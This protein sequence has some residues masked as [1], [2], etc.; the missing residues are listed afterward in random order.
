M[1]Y[2]GMDVHARMTMICVLDSHGKRRM[3]K[4]VQGVPGAVVV[5]IEDLK[6]QLAGPLAICFE[7]SCGYGWLYERLRPLAEKVV[8]AHPG[9][10]RMIFRS[11]RKSD[12]IDA[13][14]LAKLLYL[15]E[16][17][18]VHVPQANKR[19]WRRMIEYRNR[20]VVTGTLSARGGQRRFLVLVAP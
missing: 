15:N 19:A 8:V 9:Q 11:R 18:A 7:A 20:L 16:V 10:V 2:L 1:Y 17:P 4:K 13:E 6:R 14:K 3:T 12:R 5:A